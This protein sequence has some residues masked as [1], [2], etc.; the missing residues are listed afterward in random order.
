MNARWAEIEPGSN[1]IVTINIDPEV[2]DDKN[3][4]YLNAVSSPARP[5]RT[6][7]LQGVL[8]C[9]LIRV[10]SA[11]D[12]CV[13]SA[14]D[15]PG[16]SEQIADTTQHSVEG[17]VPGCSVNAGPV[18]HGYLRDP[19][20]GPFE[21]RREEPVQAVESRDKRKKVTSENLPRGV[22]YAVVENRTPYAVTNP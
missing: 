19:R 3:L 4:A 21:Q 7:P 6:S 9:L 5:R 1:G 20:P 14:F 8:V 22:P 16:N 11:K 18:G 2:D 13:K 12:L 15:Q 17:A 10:R